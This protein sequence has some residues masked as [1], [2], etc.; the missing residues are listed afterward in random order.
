[1]PYAETI[2]TALLVALIVG[3]M[4]FQFIAERRNP[5]VGRIIETE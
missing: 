3:N 2:I 4:V 1:M 5:P